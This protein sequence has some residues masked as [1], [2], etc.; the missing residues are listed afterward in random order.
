MV[1]AIIHEMIVTCALGFFYPVLFIMFGG[2]GV[3]LTQ[4]KFGNGPYV[5]TL[6]WLLMLIGCG[7]LMVLICREFYARN[8]PGAPELMKDGLLAYLYP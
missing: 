1:S 6:F 4:M 2:P 8:M 7:L 5:G 3:F